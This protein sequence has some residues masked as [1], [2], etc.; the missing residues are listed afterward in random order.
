MFCLR[1]FGERATYCFPPLHQ[2]GSYFSSQFKRVEYHYCDPV[3]PT[4][5]IQRVTWLNRGVK[6][7]GGNPDTLRTALK[8]LLTKLLG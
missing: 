5:Q 8:D 7:K 6:E 3:D 2:K 1:V 4:D